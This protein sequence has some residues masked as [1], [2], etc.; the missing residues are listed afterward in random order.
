[1]EIKANIPSQAVGRLLDALTDAIRPF[2]EER[3]LRADQM[4]L[5]REDV[6]LEIAKKARARL[7]IEE[8][9]TQVS[10]W[11]CWCGPI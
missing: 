8:V 7:A 11:V 2:T 10:P 4:R 1:M 5:Q 9:S 6:L 3:G